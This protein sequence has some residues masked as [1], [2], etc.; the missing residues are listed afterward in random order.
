MAHLSCH[1]K[2]QEHIYDMCNVK[3]KT[4]RELIQHKAKHHKS[5]ELIETLKCHNKKDA[6]TKFVFSES[7]LEKILKLDA[8]DDLDEFLKET[9]VLI[10]D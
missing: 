1:T 9:R 8:G 3:S 7:M 5:K 6:N 4:A 10:K 2:H